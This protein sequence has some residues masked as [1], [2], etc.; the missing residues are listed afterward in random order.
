MN[1]VRLRSWEKSLQG[2]SH[3]GFLENHEWQGS[4][5]A[6][7]GGMKGFFRAAIQVWGE[8]TGAEEGAFEA[9]TPACF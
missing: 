5:I 1:E 2:A 6:E 4:A 8:V 7:P 3:Q 9:P